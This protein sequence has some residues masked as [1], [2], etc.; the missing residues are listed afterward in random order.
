[1]NI[2]GETPGPSGLSD[3]SGLV[4]FAFSVASDEFFADGSDKRFLVFGLE[5]T[6][7]H[8]FS[9]GSIPL[10]PGTGKGDPKAGRCAGFL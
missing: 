4:V 7:G 3:L 5:M 6:R 2:K 10:I 9:G 1:V 8:F